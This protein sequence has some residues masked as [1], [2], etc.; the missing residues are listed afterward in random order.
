MRTLGITTPDQLRQVDHRAV[1][2]WER[3][4][5]EEQGAAASTV[6]RRLSALSSLFKHLVRLVRHGAANR[7]P[8]AD[9]AR[10][11]INREEGSTLAF[12]KAQ[13]RK[14][15][16]APDEAT[17]A[18][19]RDRAIL[20]VGLQ[21]GLRRAEIAALTVGDL[22]QNRG[23]DALRLTRKGGRRDALAIHPQAAQRIR[24]YLDIAGHGGDHAGVLFRPLRGNAKPHDPA[25][26]LDPDAIDRMVRKYV[27][28]VGLAR[29]YSAHSMRAT[30]ITT[31]LENGAQLEDVQKAAGHRD[32]STTK[33]YD[34]RGYNPEK[35]ASF[36][37]TY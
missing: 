37:A 32:P 22:H 16:D 15:L 33:L 5:R 2:A 8:V 7:N 31:A 25:G 19:L 9:V 12:S 27:A 1:I 26:R 18:G 3:I 10:P 6:R 14:L 28:L 21:V 4:M 13:A 17:L 36:F 35:A 29:G 23:F 34:R 20:S 11:N 24:A 30:F